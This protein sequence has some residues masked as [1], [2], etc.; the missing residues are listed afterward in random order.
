MTQNAKG[1]EVGIVPARQL[2][3]FAS[4][5]PGVRLHLHDHHAAERGLER[6]P[7]CQLAL[8]TPPCSPSSL[9]GADIPVQLGWNLRVTHSMTL[10]FLFGSYREGP[11]HAEPTPPCPTPHS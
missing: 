1:G 7:C 9:G 5:F 4:H 10:V 2:F 8:P 6:W 3:L 11:F